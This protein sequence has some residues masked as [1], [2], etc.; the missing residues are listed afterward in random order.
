MNIGYL[1]QNGVTSTPEATTNGLGGTLPRPASAGAAAVPSRTHED[2]I[3][4]D[5]PPSTI[6]PKTPPA[7]GVSRASSRHRGVSNLRKQHS[8]SCANH[9]CESKT[10]VWHHAYVDGNGHAFSYHDPAFFC[11]W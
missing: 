8:V 7:G 2:T 9:C 3:L 5:Y 11:E 10:K 4:Y 1:D 6:G